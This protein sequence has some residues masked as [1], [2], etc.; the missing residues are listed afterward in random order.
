[1]ELS[2]IHALLTERF[3]EAVAP[4]AAPEAGD[5]WIGIKP[6]A[7]AKVCKFLRDDARLKFDCTCA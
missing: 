6:E 3:G 7:L 4:L 5:P 1:M 2:Q